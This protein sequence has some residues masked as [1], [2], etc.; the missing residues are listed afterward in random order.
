M[1]ALRAAELLEKYSGDIKAIERLD[2]TYDVLRLVGAVVGLKAL[3]ETVVGSSDPKLRLAA[4]KELTKL[5][6]DP[7]VVV[8]RLR[9][10]PQ[11]HLSVEQLEAMIATGELDPEKA[12]AQTHLIAGDIDNA[13]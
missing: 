12:L 11:S 4:A 13:T 9:S 3:L 1:K 10:L 8:E 2:Y 6:E 7:E 5:D